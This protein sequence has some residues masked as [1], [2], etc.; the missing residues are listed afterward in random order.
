MEEEM[1]DVDHDRFTERQLA[2]IIIS[3]IAI[4]FVMLLNI[5]FLDFYTNY[6]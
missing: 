5:S 3:T 6:L 2:I 1:K 4:F